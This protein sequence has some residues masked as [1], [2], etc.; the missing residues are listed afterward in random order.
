MNQQQ[1]SQFEVA[2]DY[3]NTLC[4]ESGTWLLDQR[5]AAARRFAD[6]GYPHT[7]MEAWRYTHIDGL[8]KQAFNLHDTPCVFSKNAVMRHFLSEP[9]AARVVFVD[10]LYQP[11]LSCCKTPGVVLGNLQTAMSNND[12][13]V[14]EAVGALS[15]V[16]EH[17]FMALN[18]ATLND[19]AVLRI[20][21]GIRPPQPIELLHVT[22]RGSKGRAL[23][24]RHVIQLEEGASA[25]LVERYL[26]LEDAADCFNNLVCEIRLAKEAKL[27]HQRVQLEGALTYHLSEIYLELAAAAHYQGIQASLGAAWSRTAWHNRFTDHG[28]N[29]ELEGLYL[30]GNGQLSD[31][32]LNLD[33]AVPDCVSR[34]NFKGILY[35]AGRAV[36]DGLIQVRE[37]AQKSKAHLHNANLMLSRQ[38]EIDTKP[39]LVI[40]AD[41]VQCSHGTTVGQLDPEAIF[42]LRSRGLSKQRAH[43]LLCLGFSREIIER[44]TSADLRDQLMQVITQSIKSDQ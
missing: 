13:Q 20:K 26:N 3:I 34:E 1:Q 30:A 16:G 41:D 27:T 9:V 4:Q 32:H 23:R 44:F 38:A 22:T 24:S 5:Q 39:Q 42:Y 10:G 17:G 37:Q 18:L 2:S 33:H 6:I 19:G 40:L 43:R 8:L 14:L 31:I 11:D 25:N 29:C 36:F 21:S 7:G 35:G 12:H 15:G 28:A